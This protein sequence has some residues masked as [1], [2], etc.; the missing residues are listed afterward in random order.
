MRL[1]FISITLLVFIACSFIYLLTPS[2][3]FASGY[4]R[5]GPAI[6]QR[7]KNGLQVIVAPSNNSD[8]ATIDVWV[9]A[10]TRR[11]TSENNGVAHFIEH[12]L[13]KGTPSRK[14]G[15]IDAAIEDI[16]GSLNAATSYD[17]AHFYVTVASSDAETALAIM[18]DA[19]R[20]AE[21]RQQDMDKERQVILNEM[22]RE[23]DTPAKRLTKIV[24]GMMFGNHPYG[25]PLLGTEQTVSNM[26]RQT[27]IDF[28]HAYY[29]PGNTTL[30]ISGA[31]SP[32]LGFDM[33]EKS[34]GSWSD[35]PLPSDNVL[36]APVLPTLQVCQKSEAVSRGYLAMGFRAPSVRRRPD[37]Y[38]MD[39]LLTLLGQ[40]GLNRLDTDIVHNRKLA[41]S[42]ESNY[43]TQRDPGILTIS[44][45]FDPANLEALV[46]AILDE[47]INLRTAPV[48]PD[49]LAKAKHALLASYLFDVQTT[50]GRAN[51][52]GFYN[53]IDTYEYDVDYIDNFESV[54]SE[55]IQQVA[56]TYLDPESYTLATIMPRVDTKAA[57]SE[58]STAI[59]RSN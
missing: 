49:E 34:F 33:A 31:V 4:P 42:I 50:S 53:I 7:L 15:E 30:V 28:Y 32:K 47:V 56:R 52:L 41:L 11:E 57:R 8:L 58:N 26:S 29:V 35:R 14:P 3:S 40:G 17:W 2:P 43:L 22:A 59:A 12:L 37:A 5:L 1:R 38:V 23:D 27:A 25:R 13:F 39:V 24:N 6:H 54:T 18:S 45:T 20:N 55:Q 16:G 46:K 44:A 48:A 10:G 36:P 21:L 19:I 51:A 9:G